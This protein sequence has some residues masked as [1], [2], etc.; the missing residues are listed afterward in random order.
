[1]DYIEMF[2]NIIGSGKNADAIT[3][4]Q[5]NEA[6]F[7][8]YIHVYQQVKQTLDSVKHIADGAKRNEKITRHIYRVLINRNRHID[9]LYV[10]AFFP[11]MLLGVVAYHFSD[12]F[13]GVIALICIIAIIISNLIF[14]S[15]SDEDALLDLVRDGEKACMSASATE[16]T[17]N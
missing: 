2:K 5:T 6:L 8:D 9:F 10:I 14:K 4:E 13:L 11:S 16:L 3:D 12:I 15:K 1:M 17:N 7:A